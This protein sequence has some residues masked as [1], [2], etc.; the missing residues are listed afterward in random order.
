MDICPFSKNRLT[1]TPTLK[2]YCIYTPKLLHTYTGHQN[3]NVYSRYY[4]PYTHLTGLAGYSTVSPG[5]VS[6]GFGTEERNGKIHGQKGGCSKPF[7]YLQKLSLVRIICKWIILDSKEGC[8]AFLSSLKFKIFPPG[9]SI[10]AVFVCLFLLGPPLQE[11]IS[12][13]QSMLLRPCKRGFPPPPQH[14][15]GGSTASPWNH[16]A[17]ACL[18]RPEA[19][20]EYGLLNS[21]ECLYYTYSAE[22][23]HAK[24]P[25]Y[26]EY[27]EIQ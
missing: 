15:P 17:I 9:N 2:R 12:A 13:D 4:K 7:Y 8:F 10:E 20:C 22:M 24:Q 1:N 18:K 11:P 6:S 21:L 3:K 14:S 23:N 27:A 16:W 26:T 5:T 19:R 25:G